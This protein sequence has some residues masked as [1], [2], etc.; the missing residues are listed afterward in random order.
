MR[1]LFSVA[2]NL[3]SRGYKTSVSDDGRFQIE[4][5]HW[6]EKN[7][8]YYILKNLYKVM[9]NIETNEPHKKSS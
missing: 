4:T 6:E 3:Q 5:D 7:K 1:N 8:H 9:V 2:L